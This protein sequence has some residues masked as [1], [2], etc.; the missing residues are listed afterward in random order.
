VISVARSLDSRG[1]RCCLNLDNPVSV[2]T[3]LRVW[4]PVRSRYLSFSA[5][6]YS[7]LRV[8]KQPDCDADDSSLSNVE[9][10]NEWSHTSI[11]SYVLISWC[12]ELYFYIVGY[13][14]VGT[15]MDCWEEL[16]IQALH[17]RKVLITEQQVND[18]NPLFELAVI[19]HTDSTITYP[20]T[21]RH[22][23]A[24]CTRAHEN[25]W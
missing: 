25:S 19:T 3:G 18:T 7:R 10:K 12:V 5:A 8:L 4:T 15:R 2:V 9:V 6:S 13:A 24:H 21:I 20:H 22:S 1:R 14:T 23:S 11:P 16:Y 17:Q